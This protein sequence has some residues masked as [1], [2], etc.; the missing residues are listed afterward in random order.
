LVVKYLLDNGANKDLKDSDGK[1]A[2]DYAL[3][4]KTLIKTNKCKSNFSE[5]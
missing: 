3:T 2:L 1:T 5:K 4:A